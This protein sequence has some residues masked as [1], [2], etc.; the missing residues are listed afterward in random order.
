MATRSGFPEVKN[1]PPFPTPARLNVVSIAFSLLIVGFL[2]RCVQHIHSFFLRSQS[3]MRYSSSF[4][5]NSSI[6]SAA[7]TSVLQ[8]L[9]SCLVIVLSYF[10]CNYCLLWCCHISNFSLAHTQVISK[11]TFFIHIHTVDVFF[12]SLI[13]LLRSLLT[14]MNYPHILNSTSSRIQLNDVENR[15]QRRFRRHI[16][17]KVQRLAEIFQGHS[18]NT[19]FIAQFYS[20]FHQ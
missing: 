1:R 5:P 9:M 6:T 10:T 2:P 3:A 15:G 14:L 20:L 4:R 18:F 17:F 19:R 12:R 13:F 16:S 8:H 11:S 7:F